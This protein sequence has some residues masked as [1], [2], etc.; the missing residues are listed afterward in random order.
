MSDTTDDIAA[1]SRIAELEG[2]LN[3]A[4]DDF[5]EARRQLLGNASLWE[6]RQFL[7]ESKRRCWAALGKWDD[8]PKEAT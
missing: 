2:A 1:E 3:Q 8:G 6:T 5:H 7:V 4:A